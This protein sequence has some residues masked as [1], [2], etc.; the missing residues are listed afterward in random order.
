MFGDPHFYTFD[1]TQYTFNGKG[2]YVLTR[3]NTDRNKID[4]QARFETVPDNERGPVLATQLTA[5]AG[6]CRVSGGGRSA[7]GGGGVTGRSGVSPCQLCVREEL[8]A[9]GYSFC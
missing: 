1:D 4:V 5:I 2:E 6:Q 7:W 8:V 3:V 9:A